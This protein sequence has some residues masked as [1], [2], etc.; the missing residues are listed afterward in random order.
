MPSPA[1]KDPAGPD[2]SASSYQ[3]D[4]QHGPEM[5]DTQVEATG[6]LADELDPV[7]DEDG[8]DGED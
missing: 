4:P 5:D 6:E 1:P 3:R 2:H 8:E 7:I